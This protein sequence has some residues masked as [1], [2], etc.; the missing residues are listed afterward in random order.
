MVR[1]CWYNCFKNLGFATI[2]NNLG[3]NLGHWKVGYGHRKN[4]RTIILVTILVRIL[5][6]WIAITSSVKNFESGNPWNNL[7]KKL[8]CGN[9]GYNLRKNLRYENFGNNIC[10][11]LGYCNLGYNLGKNLG[12]ANNGNSLVKNFSVWEY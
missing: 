3:K 8:G 7:G 11:D 6:A 4:L 10:K 2:L 12:F 5:D 1:E 9:D